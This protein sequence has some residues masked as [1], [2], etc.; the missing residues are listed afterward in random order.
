[1]SSSMEFQGIDSLISKIDAMGK[2]GL[3]IEKTA[4]KKA[5]E[6]ILDEA[7]DILES[8]GHVRTGKLKKGLKVSGLKRKGNKKYI[9]VG[10]QKGDN[11]NIFYGKFLEWGTSKMSAKPFLGPAYENK[12]EEAKEIIINE[13]K[14]GLRL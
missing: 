13:I 6:S 2:A 14:R 5:G 8:D 3:K 9:N 7:R 11:S 1:M 12:R 10:I 4:L